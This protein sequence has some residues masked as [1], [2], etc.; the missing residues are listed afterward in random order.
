[1]SGNNDSYSRRLPVGAEPIHASGGNC[2][3]THFRVW[4]PACREVK[5]VHGQDEAK[6]QPLVR[7][8]NGEKGGEENGYFSGFCDEIFPGGIYRYQLNGDICRADPASRFQPNGPHGPSE[9]VDPTLFA[10]TDSSWAGV[11][12]EGQ[13][14]YE[15]HIGTFTQQGTWRAAEEQLGELA[16]IGLTVIEIMPVADFPGRFGWG[17][18]G[19]FMFAP[20]WAYGSPDDFRSFVNRAHQVGLG[21]IL[22]VVYNHFGPDGNFLKSFSEDYFTTKY[23][24]DWGE[25]INFDGPNCRPVRE[26]FRANARYWIEE[27]H[28]DGLRL[29]ATQQVFDDSKPNI[30]GEIR[31]AVRDAAQ[32]RA[33]FVVG[34]NEPQDTKLLRPEASGGYELDALWNDDFHHTAVVAL[35]GHN[36]AY[37]TDYKGTSQEFLSCAKYGFLFQ[38]QRYKWQKQPRGTPALD[39]K[40]S[41]FITFIEN[42]DQVANSASG[43]RLSRLSHPAAYRAMTALLL[44]S[45]GTPM[46]FQGQ[47]YGST[48]PF[49]YFADHTPELSHRIQK[50][51]TEFLAQFRSLDCK[52]GTP[53]ISDPG[54]PSTF[55]HCKLDFGER[56]TNAK[57]YTL[58]KDLIRLRRDDPTLRR[59]A[60][61]ACWDGAILSDKAFLMRFFGCGQDDRLLLF[62]FGMDLYLNPAPEPLLA[63]PLGAGWEMLWSS[64]DPAYGGSGMYCPD[65]EDGWRLPGNAAVVLKPGPAREK[66]TPKLVKKPA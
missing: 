29:D 20:Y 12:A 63:P 61:A 8:T 6:C 47:E 37:Y 5:V 18:D 54:S 48:A 42:H 53:F 35:N 64:E 41:N 32:G 57:I 58:H 50:G 28:L 24:N 45:P 31:Q 1:M 34:E 65:T 14:L 17:Y 59:Q 49:L 39:L 21:V 23:L 52:E 9:V 3:G 11:K 27:F 7:E 26:F 19:V 60:P 40:P 2:T 13:V 66:K 10:W 4:A 55:E 56:V 15:M 44:L 30:L 51:R 62:N 46:I 25:A 36:E 16:A 33:T 38:G 43:E 22:D